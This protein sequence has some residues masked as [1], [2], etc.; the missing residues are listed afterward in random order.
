MM[1]I[2][3]LVKKFKRINEIYGLR[4]AIGR[5]FHFIGNIEGRKI[6]R[7][8]RKKAKNNRGDVLFIN[9]CA[10]EHPMRYRV[11]H[12]MEQLQEAGLVCAKVYFE[13]IELE[14]EHNYRTFIFYRCEYTPEVERFI[15]EARKHG[16]KICFDVD[17]LITD[18]KYT[19]QVP[20]VQELS[21]LDK[22]L[23]DASVMNIG[24]TLAVCDIATTTTEALAAE[25]G[26]IAPDVYIN[27][28]TASKEM[29]ANSEAAFNRRKDRVD[30]DCNKVWIGY[31]SG[32]LTHNKDFE[33]VHPALMRIMEENSNVGL[34]LVGE[35]EASDMLMKFKDRIV[36]RPAVDWR[37]LPELISEADINLAPLEDTLF[38]ECKS[39][40]KWSEAA[41]VKVPTIA[42][43]I[44]A[45]EKMI[46]NNVTG[47]LCDNSDASWYE[48]L[49]RLITDSKLRREI[50]D[51]AYD[52]A[53][54][55]CTTTG[56][57]EEYRLFIE[58][59]M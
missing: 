23:F 53:K 5:V 49:E 9:G 32:S 37:K 20:F 35:L 56:S 21:K 26:K 44:G 47:V 39:E 17:D 6:R 24:K 55:H 13:D 1:K 57:A 2:V 42:S 54:K 14:M 41:L 36:K 3:K 46:E 15:L 58:T 16:K 33:I 29:V 27:R 11:L 50:A 10:V 22:E 31:F 48:G 40:I 43:R 8:D 18:T 59:L 52:F 38:N 4:I 34:I 51:N 12:Q 19:D 7:T 30:S 25:L 45:F 28:N